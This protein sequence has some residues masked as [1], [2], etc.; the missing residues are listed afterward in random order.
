[1]A[2]SHY[3]LPI[4][5]EN[6]HMIKHYSLLALQKAINHA[7]RLDPDT[8]PK[9]QSLDQK[10]I[11]IIISPL[12]VYFFMRFH[13]SEIELLD[14]YQGEPDT[15]IHSSP[16]G[17]IR[18][19]LLPVSNVRSLFHDQIKITGDTELGQA[20]K[21]L[22]DEIDIDW[23]GHLA[24]FTGDVVAH[25]VGRF[26]KRGKAFQTRLKSS[27]K[28]NVSEYIQ[29]EAKLTPPQEALEDFMNDIDALVLRV[30]RLEAQINQDLTSDLINHE[31]P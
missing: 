26:V 17:L 28:H 5:I 6:L 10:V 31:T 20:V 15:V 16:L 3:T 30:E 2:L 14:N 4:N 18:L 8:P 21:Q 27:L 22:F 13:N 9:L 7:L 1:V 11:E 29:E 25:Q 12:N 23:E 19:S 24:H